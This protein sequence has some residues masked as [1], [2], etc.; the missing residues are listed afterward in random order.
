MSR[1]KGI[2]ISGF[3]GDR[4]WDSGENKALELGSAGYE[5]QETGFVEHEATND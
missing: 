3:S 1:K 4:E 2:H 5:F